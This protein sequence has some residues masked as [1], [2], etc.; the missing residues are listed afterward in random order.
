MS[1]VEW[2]DIIGCFG[3]AQICAFD[4]LV[5]SGRER[6]DHGYD[7][8]ILNLTLLCIEEIIDSTKLALDLA[9]N[10]CTCSGW[11]MSEHL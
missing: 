6:S 8:G 1:D 7:L 2:T 11:A 9:V 4:R 5:E 10:T 3:L